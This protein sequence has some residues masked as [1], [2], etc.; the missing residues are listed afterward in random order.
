MALYRCPVN[1]RHAE[2]KKNMS[3]E[4]VAADGRGEK[5]GEV[6]LLWIFKDSNTALTYQNETNIKRAYERWKTHGY[7]VKLWTFRP[8]PALDGLRGI[9]V[10]F[11][12]DHIA[13]EPYLRDL[14][15]ESVPV[16]L[17]VDVAKM[18]VPYFVMRST[19]KRPRLWSWIFGRTNEGPSHC[20]VSDIDI[21]GGCDSTTPLEDVV[22]KEKLNAHGFLMAENGRKYENWFLVFKNEEAVVRSIEDFFIR[23]RLTYFSSQ[24]VWNVLPHFYRYLQVRRGKM[25]F[26]FDDREVMPDDV[27]GYGY[28]GELGFELDSVCRRS[29]VETRVW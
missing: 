14:F 3:F 17:R 6:I 24:G 22:P 28:Y 11:I 19:W 20:V 18:I 21:E 25:G 4:N 8:T 7:S 2:I 1:T 23:Q 29:S 12:E 27:L 5:D 26:K 9:D 13:D 10:C 16:Y 15:S